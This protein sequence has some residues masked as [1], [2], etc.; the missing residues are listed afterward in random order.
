M[1]S[2]RQLPFLLV[3]VVWWDLDAYEGFGCDAGFEE[4]AG[5]HFEVVVDCAVEVGWGDGCGVGF[6]EE[7]H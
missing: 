1:R 5:E 6:D 3:R 7:G 4:G 2:P